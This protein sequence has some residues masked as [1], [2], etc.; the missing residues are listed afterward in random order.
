[1][2]IY[3]HSITGTEFNELPSTGAMRIKT[4]EDGSSW[5]R[6]HWLNVIKDASYF[7]SEVEAKDCIKTNRF[8]A[9]GA[10]DQLASSQVTLTN[11][12]FEINGIENFSSSSNAASYT[13]EGWRKYSNAS[14]QLTG[15][16]AAETTLQSATACIPL[17]NGN[18]Y[19]VRF[20]IKQPAVVG[21][22]QIYLG[23]TTAGSITEP[24]FFSGKAVSAA[25]K[26]TAVSGLTTRTFPTGNHKFRL[27]FDNS[28]T[29]AAYF[30]EFVKAYLTNETIDQRM[31]SL[32]HMKA[33][34]QMSRVAS[35]VGP[36]P[37]LLPIIKINKYIICVW[38]SC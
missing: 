22:A 29:S 2:G 37:H 36:V 8:S 7:T 3:L 9:L 21:K 31:I 5:A 20:E 30:S 26:W 38:F 33:S 15:T 24:S 35:H 16:T 34:L 6:I 11:L 28:G 18:K 1:M 23:G 13:A 27:D 4:L 12:A 14:L 25:N 19:Y 32:A 17:I 10:V